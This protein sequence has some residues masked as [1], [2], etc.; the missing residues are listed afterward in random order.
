MAIRS[1]LLGIAVLVSA[2]S[3]ADW[4]TS[5]LQAFGE[6]QVAC[7]FLF[8]IGKAD[9]LDNAIQ[10]AG[11]LAA[12]AKITGQDCFYVL[13]DT[14][15]EF[16]IKDYQQPIKTVKIDSPKRLL[17]QALALILT[18]CG[19][20]HIEHV[21]LLNYFQEKS[22]TIAIFGA[23]P[24][25][26]DTLYLYSRVIRDVE[27]FLFGFTFSQEVMSKLRPASPR[28]LYIRNKLTGAVT[29]HEKAF[30]LEELMYTLESANNP[31]LLNFDKQDSPST[32]LG[33]EVPCLFMIDHHTES[34]E[35]EIFKM[36]ANLL[37]N[38]INFVHAD[39][40]AGIVQRLINFLLIK[41]ELGNGIWIIKAKWGKL[42][43]FRYPYTEITVENIKKFV[44]DF[45]EGKI[46]R[47]Y[48]SEA[49]PAPSGSHVIEA[50]SSTFKDLVLDDSM[51]VFVDFYGMYCGHCHTF[52]PVYEELAARFVSFPKMRFVKIEMTKNEVENEEIQEFPTLKLYP[53]GR[54]STPIW[55]NGNRNLPTLIE[56]IK[57]SIPNEAFEDI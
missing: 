56:F 4:P 14:K 49:S 51:H 13:E 53:A 54:K 24:T 12:L 42:S 17:E 15:G 8:A 21:G 7:K 52:V 27:G 43:K 6:L 22:K 55:F 45:D 47:Y 31:L 34:R 20:T 9:T 37:R 41:N 16:H 39:P 33:R 30:T 2:V 10:Q 1:L 36:A 50:V 32:I 26:L 18:H 25:D 38:E 23:L 57:N 35:F 5:T 40:E 28:V 29:L 19:A 44:E 46:S 3:S 48:H 11:Q